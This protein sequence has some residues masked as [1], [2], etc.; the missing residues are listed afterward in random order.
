MSTAA[1]NR[2]KKTRQTLK[3]TPR[4]KRRMRSWMEETLQL[5]AR[6]LSY[7]YVVL[8]L[9]HTLAN[10]FTWWGV[11]A[12]PFRPES[13]VAI[14]CISER[15]LRMFLFSRSPWCCIF[16]ST[17]NRDK[18]LLLATLILTYLHSPDE[19]SYC[20]VST[21]KNY[22]VF[23]SLMVLVYNVPFLFIT[24]HQSWWIL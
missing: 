16:V 18:R 15:L 22:C 21:R 13:V 23:L 11:H 5:V 20:I 12:K 19:G 24:Q 14:W 4:I 8:F 6:F 7:R 17:G 1:E 10:F 2:Q 9:Y 3:T